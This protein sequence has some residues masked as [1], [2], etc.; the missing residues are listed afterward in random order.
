MNKKIL[1]LTISF[2]FILNGC[3]NRGMTSKQSGF[4]D[5]YESLQPSPYEKGALMYI[6]PGAK[7][8]SYENVII[9]PVR[10]IVNNEEIKAD[11]G[12]LKEMSDYLTNR[13][14]KAIEINDKF[15]LV[16]QVKENTL[17]V[18]IALTAVIVTH[19]DI[20]VYQF[21]PVA[22]V[23]T[24]AARATSIINEKARVLAEMKVTDVTTNES[25]IRVIDLQKGKRVDI[26]R[27]EVTF[28]LVKPVV[29]TWA[30]RFASRLKYLK[31]KKK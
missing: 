12:L 24:G 14:R 18:E 15:E 9:E 29:D 17:R 23:L 2:L 1:L 3:S 28:E 5:D 20:Q 8:A 16:E 30:E 13:A 11:T 21:I 25:L 4:L 19:D 7:V 10:I 6:S 27:Q 31:E 22:L 26:R